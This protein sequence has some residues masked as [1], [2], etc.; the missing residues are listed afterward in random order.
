MRARSRRGRPATY[1]RLL[2][3]GTIQ[4]YDGVHD[5]AAAAARSPRPQPQLPAGVA[6]RRPS[7]AGR[8][9]SRRRSRRSARWSRRSSRART[10]AGTSPTTRSR[11]CIL[12]PYGGRTPTITSRRATCASTRQ[13]GEACD[14]DHRATSRLGVPRLQVRPEDR[15]SRARATSGCTTTSG[16]S[17]WTTE[18]WSPI[19]AGRDHGLQVHRLVRRPPAPRTTCSSY[20]WNDEKLDGRGFVDWYPFDHPQLG[21]GR[22][23]RLGLLPRLVQR[24]VE[25]LEAE[26]APHSEWAIFHLSDLAA[27]RDALG[28][29]RARG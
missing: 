27:A 14:G 10:S 24:A 18:F 23:R 7:S 15:R 5:P 12:R 16:S 22:D 26:V 3:E 8:G 11:G 9:R 19:R 17:A 25:Q 29:R 1:Y 4:S 20:R 2:P 21:R 28:R 13:L 6:A